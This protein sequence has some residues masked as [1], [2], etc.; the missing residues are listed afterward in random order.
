M[1]TIVKWIIWLFSSDTTIIECKYVDIPSSTIVKM[2]IQK[3]KEEESEWLEEPDYERDIAID[4]LESV[5]AY[6]YELDT[7]K[8]K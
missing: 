3:I 5:L 4:V 2:I 7:R 8:L 1:K 6:I